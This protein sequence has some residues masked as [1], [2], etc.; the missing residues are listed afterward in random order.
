[1]KRAV[2]IQDLSCFGKCSLTIALPLISAMGVECAVLPTAVL[3]TH[4]G[5]FT[6]IVFRDLSTDLPDIAA[7]WKKENLAF[8]GLYTGY[9]GS[10]AQAAFIERFIDDFRPP[11]VFVDPVMGDGGR[12]YHGMDAAIVPAMKQ[13]CSRA[14]F[15]VPNLTEAALLTGE[16][17]VRPGEYDAAYIRGMLVRL[18]G[19][20]ARISAITGVMYDDRRQGIVAY[21]RASD[22]FAE[23]FTENLPVQYHGTG[24]VFASTL[25]ASLLLSKSLSESLK[26][27]A[28][29]TVNCIRRTLGVSDSR[30]GVN[31][32]EGIPELLKML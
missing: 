14:D 3:S 15:I 24:D 6:G 7:H 9:L 19:L 2:T 13:L 32:E 21:D 29:N 26:I 27:A 8:D 1:M 22:T 28:D 12:L 17:F 5:G 16:D 4:T 20:G 18:S 30:C 10:P 23:Y 25:F 31:F 11:L